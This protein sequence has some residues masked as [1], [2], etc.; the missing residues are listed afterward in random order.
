MLWLRTVFFSCRACS[1]WKINLLA[2]NKCHSADLH[3]FSASLCERGI[4]KSYLMKACDSLP[5]L[6]FSSFLLSI[7]GR[8]PCFIEQ[9]VLENG[10][11]I[12]HVGGHVSIESHNAVHFAGLLSPVYVLSPA[13]QK[14]PIPPQTCWTTALPVD[15]QKQV[16]KS[17]NTRPIP[18][19]SFHRLLI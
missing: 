17:A 4:F 8:L 5:P 11:L 16:S 2:K 12:W 14:L 19:D 3:L 9:T 1:C 10:S 15:C 7:I 18:F 13:Q 6:T